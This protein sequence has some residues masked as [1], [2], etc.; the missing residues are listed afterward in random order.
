MSDDPIDR[1]AI[2]SDPTTEFHR[3]EQI[4]RSATDALFKYTKKQRVA[5]ASHARSRIQPH[6]DIRDGSIV[7]VWRSKAKLRGWVGP[8]LV[9]CVNGT[10]T[11]AWVS[12]RGILIKTNMERLRLATDTEWLGAE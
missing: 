2:A 8:G 7:Y 6:Q 10:K 12:M 9:V 4:R 11:S 1:H 3:A 5:D